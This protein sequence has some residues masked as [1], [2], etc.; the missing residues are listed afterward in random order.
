[1]SDE[2]LQD[3]QFF[4]QK[5]CFPPDLLPNSNSNLEL[6]V[7][8]LSGLTN[9]VFKIEV[10]GLDIPFV[11]HKFSN[12]F[13]L[14]IDHSFENNVIKKLSENRLY[15]EIFYADN[16]Q[17]IE[18]FYPG[19]PIDLKEFQDFAIL[20]GLLFQLSYIHSNL[21]GTMSNKDNDFL[22]DKITKKPDFLKLL[23]CEIEKR[24]EFLSEEKKSK[25]LNIYHEVLGI[26]YQLKL[27][28]F[29][30]K[31]KN[32]QEIYE[33]PLDLYYVMCHN[34][35]NNT[36]ILIKENK[37]PLSLRVI[38]YEYSSP[39]Y[40]VYEFANLFNE[41]ATDYSY[42]QAPYFH[43]DTSKY[44]DIDFRMKFFLIYCF[45][46]KIWKNKQKETVYFEMEFN[47][48]QPTK[49]DFAQI[50]KE[51][52][53]VIKGLEEGTFYASVFSHY[54]W[55]IVAGLSL[56]MKDLGIDLYE[57]IIMRYEILKKTLFE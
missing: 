29:L 37:N 2:F 11:Y 17:R 18:K 6:K 47:E 32:I 25:L 39:N 35:L 55:F 4:R 49:E 43:Y 53:N 52:G 16:E 12:N 28:T 31:L 48:N 26:D 22:L 1:M 41:F 54:F 46:H 3:Y 44:P 40:L 9:N 20:K 33:I 14:L 15:V 38:D 10:P 19:L 5:G 7:T 27:E 34:D 50:A 8:R 30:K 45:Y 51:Y 21:F 56:N 42:P 23:S 36:N 13:K 24:M 57:Y